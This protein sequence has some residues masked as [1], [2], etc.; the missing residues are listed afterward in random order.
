MDGEGKGRYT[1]GTALLN[2]TTNLHGQFEKFMR[3]CR[4][5]D[6]HILNEIYVIN[7]RILQ[8]RAAFGSTA[9]HIVGLLFFPFSFSYFL[10]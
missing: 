9:V 2:N 5:G 7:K 8:S 10:Q 3:A 4:S 1:G 6:V